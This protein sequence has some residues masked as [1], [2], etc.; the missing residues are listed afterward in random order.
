MAEHHADEG[1][2]A[3]PL[4]PSG[5]VL[6]AAESSVSLHLGVVRGPTRD[7]DGWCAPDTRVVHTRETKG[8][9]GTYTLTIPLGEVRESGYVRL[10]GSDGRRHG[11]GLRGRAVDP[12]GPLPHPP[13]DGDPWADTWLY[14]NPIFIE[15]T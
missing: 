6:P 9:K 12:H 14:T 4:P 13:G 3:S 7:R 15:L 2:P 8:R 10:R 5:A 1:V 11:P